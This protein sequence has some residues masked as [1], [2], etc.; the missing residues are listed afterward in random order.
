MLRVYSLLDVHKY[1]ITCKQWM[2]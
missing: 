2:L 1:D